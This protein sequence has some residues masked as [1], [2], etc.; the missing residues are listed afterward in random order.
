MSLHLVSTSGLSLGKESSA[1]LY[2]GNL[3]VSLGTVTY[4]LKILVIPVSL[5]LPQDLQL[6][7]FR[8]GYL[9]VDTYTIFFAEIFCFRETV[10]HQAPIGSLS[11]HRAPWH[12][13]EFRWRRALCAVALT[14][15]VSYASSINPSG[16]RRSWGRCQ[17]ST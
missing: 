14:A 13:R 7:R 2:G 15:T 17:L 1:L 6:E 4:Q 3:A 12:L 8:R 10:M 5:Q 16:Q 9:Y 11:H